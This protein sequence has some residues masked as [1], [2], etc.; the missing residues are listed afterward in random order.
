MTSQS[1]Y[2][3]VLGFDPNEGQYESSTTTTTRRSGTRHIHHQHHSSSSSSGTVVAGH[4]HTQ[5]S[6]HSQQQHRSHQHHHQT[7][8][9][10]SPARISISPGGASLD[11][12][13]DT[14][15]AKKAKHS[16]ALQN[17]QGGY[18]DAL[19][20]FKGTMSVWE[21]FIEN[22]DILRKSVCFSTGC[23]P[24]QMPKMARF[25]ISSF[26]AVVIC[27]E[28]LLFMFVIPCQR[29]VFFVRGTKAAFLFT[30]LASWCYDFS[31][32]KSLFCIANLFQGISAALLLS[33]TK[34]WNNAELLNKRK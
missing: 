2:K 3:D 16:S 21:Y 31:N 5:H 19:T 32:P 11:H 33:L 23:L 7:S 20:Q 17:P 34:V 30:V 12:Y 24:E 8:S 22:W 13:A 27:F 4:H 26:L 1:Y 15:P 6:H 10:A 25:K 29:I 18:E 28:L 14:S 9:A